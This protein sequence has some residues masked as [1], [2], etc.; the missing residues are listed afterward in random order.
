[1]GDCAAYVKEAESLGYSSCWI[2]EVGSNDA[3]ALGCAVASVTDGMRIGTAVSPMN[4]RGIALLAQQ[5]ATLNAVSHGRAVCGIGVSSEQ[6]VSRWNGMPYEKHLQRTRETVDVLKRIFSGERVDYEGDTVHI[7]GYRLGAA[8]IPVYIGALN[9]RMLH[10]GAEVADGVVVNMFGERF[11]PKVVDEVRKGAR[12]AGRDPASI[13][14][15]MRVQ[16]VVDQDPAQARELF[17]RGFGAYIIAP[18]Y[19]RFFTW[20]GYGEVVEGVRKG[21]AAKDREASRRAISDDMLEQLVFAGDAP[22]VR[23]RFRALMDAGITTPAAHNLWINPDS[24]WTTMRSL[25]PGA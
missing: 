1:M 13:E 14:I 20:Q 24:A 17:G 7:K 23:S 18:G 10:L 3:F 15:V 11:A 2:A 12:K 19:D 25:A 22:T 8:P 9:K 4:T 21:F 16:C 6:I 5:A